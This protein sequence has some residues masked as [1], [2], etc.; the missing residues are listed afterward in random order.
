MCNSRCG[1]VLVT[2]KVC[3][4]QCH[5][6]LVAAIDR[7]RH[8][9]TERRTKFVRKK[10]KKYHMARLQRNR[11]VA[12]LYLS[13]AIHQRG[14][15][16]I[17]NFPPPKNSYLSVWMIGRWKY[18]FYLSDWID[19]YSHAWKTKSLAVSRRVETEFGAMRCKRH[20]MRSQPLYNANV[21]G[22]IDD[23]SAKFDVSMAI[24]CHSYW[25]IHSVGLSDTQFPIYCEIQFLLCLS[26]RFP[27]RLKWMTVVSDFKLIS[28]IFR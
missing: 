10:W 12:M 14:F 2:H 3:V 13:V 23:L 16:G 1:N 15:D 21:S 17:R 22:K 19:A 25:V 5:W 24:V 7:W 6:M 11:T 8:Q 4:L 26:R 28:K 20:A 9:T 27:I 18:L